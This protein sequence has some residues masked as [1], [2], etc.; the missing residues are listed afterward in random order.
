MYNMLRP[1][2][3]MATVTL[4]CVQESGSKLRVRITTP[5]YLREANCQFPR[6]IRSAGRTYTAPAT[7]VRL[8]SGPRGKYFYRVDKKSIKI[9]ETTTTTPTIVG[10][11]HVHVY[12]DDDPT[13]VI[14]MDAPK[15]LVFVPCGHYCSCASCVTGLK[16]K[17]P[18]CREIITAAVGRDQVE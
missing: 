16:N 4:Q 2:E 17:C 1:Y 8:V 7:A 6:D 12:G 5:G 18:M 9:V 13:C 10:P 15:A 3:K 11:V 14:C